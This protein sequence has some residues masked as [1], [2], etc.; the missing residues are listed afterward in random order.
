MIYGSGHGVIQG[1]KGWTGKSFL[2]TLCHPDGGSAVSSLQNCQQTEFN[3]WLVLYLVIDASPGSH[4][5]GR[6]EPP[7]GSSCPA[8]H[9]PSLPALCSLVSHLSLV[10]D[11]KGDLYSRTSF[12]LTG[13]LY[14]SVL[15]HMQI[16]KVLGE[17]HTQKSS[18]G[19]PAVTGLTQIQDKEIVLQ[20]E[21][22]GQVGKEFTFLCMF[23]WTSPMAASG[24]SAS[25]PN[26][27][28]QSD[29][30]NGWLDT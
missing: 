1:F 18:T 9:L 13:C 22:E 3:T 24:S 2:A 29:F 28:D 26:L 30:L 17:T 25:S 20:Y 14:Q 12:R 19:L 15:L 21:K 11:P 23:I 5:P 6:R 7:I 16:F 27:T 4:Y 10:I 8:D